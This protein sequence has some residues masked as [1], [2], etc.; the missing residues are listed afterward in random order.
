MGVG[1]SADMRELLAQ[2]ARGDPRAGLAIEMFIDRA[3]AGIAAAA[4]ALDGLDALVFTGGIG[5]GA[6]R[7][8]SRICRRLAL[9]GVPEPTD[10]GVAGSGVRVLS[11]GA[12]AVI[13]VH[14]REDVLIARERY[15][16]FAIGR[17]QPDA[18]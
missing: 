2:G 12:P 18:R 10:V 7:V 17:L 8:R 9:L 1:G 15:P 5:E 14:A 16:G 13:A 4:T 11:S 6:C 3:A